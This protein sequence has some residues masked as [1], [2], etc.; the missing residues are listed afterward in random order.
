MTGNNKSSRQG[1][2][3]AATESKWHNHFG[4]PNCFLQNY[5]IPYYSAL[6]LQVIYPRTN[7][8]P[9]KDLY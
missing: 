4:K 6:P 1:S 3:A 8:F 2:E 9:E 7:V 5:I